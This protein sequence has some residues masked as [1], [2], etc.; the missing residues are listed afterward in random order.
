MELGAPLEL[1]IELGLGLGRGWVRRV[2]TQGENAG[3]DERPHE[4]PGVGRVGQ[5]GVR[6]G[7]RAVGHHDAHGPLGGSGRLL[8]LEPPGEERRAQV[9]RHPHDLVEAAEGDVGQDGAGF[10][11]E[12]VGQRLVPAEPAGRLDHARHQHV[13]QVAG[14]AHGDGQGREEPGHLRLDDGGQDSLLAPGERPVGR[15][16][17]QSSGTGDVVH[18]GL[19]DPLAG[20]AAQRPVDEADPGRGAVVRPEMPDDGVAPPVGD[21]IS[22]ASDRVAVA[23]TDETV[24]RFLSHCQPNGAERGYRVMGGVGVPGD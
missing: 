4:R 19:G 6:G 23:P 14:L 17:G 7:V 9:A 1:E 22:T 24:W 2:D 12:Q 3:Q 13:L 20:Q 11:L 5:V 8:G 21:W 10:V 16:P 18:R 15:G